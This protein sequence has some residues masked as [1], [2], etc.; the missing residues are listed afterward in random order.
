MSGEAMPR[1]LEELADV[2]ETAPNPAARQNFL[3]LVRAA[4]DELD[5]RP[6]LARSL[7]K[8]LGDWALEYECGRAYPYETIRWMAY[9]WVEALDARL[10][11][12]P[13]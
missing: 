9:A 3:A 6:R 4:A 10:G 1:T 5:D 13:A 2:I 7:L 12:D 11:R 8:A